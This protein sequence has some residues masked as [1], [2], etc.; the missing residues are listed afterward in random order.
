[1]VKLILK[2]NLRHGFCLLNVALCF[3]GGNFVGLEVM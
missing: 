1:V 3:L 2:D